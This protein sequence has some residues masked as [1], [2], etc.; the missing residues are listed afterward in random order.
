LLTLGYQHIAES[1]EKRII[2]SCIQRN[3]YPTT[4]ADTKK[5][6]IELITWKLDTWGEN[7]TPQRRCEEVSKRFQKYFDEGSLKYVGSGTQSGY[8]ILCVLQQT[9]EGWKCKKNGIIITLQSGED[10][11]QVMKEL[12]DFNRA[13]GTGI[14]RGEMLDWEDYMDNSPIIESATEEEP[15]QCPPELC[16]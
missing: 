14:V 4:V 6:R 10:P 1:S 8:N 16:N 7:W 13:S 15:M 5:G 9:R 12:F 3:G 2:Y 11:K